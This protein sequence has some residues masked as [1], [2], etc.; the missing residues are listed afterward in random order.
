VRITV[1]PATCD[2]FGF[3]AELLPELMS[4]DEWGFPI[5]TES[6]I[7]AELLSAARQ[8]ARV[9]PRRAVLLAGQRPKAALQDG[10]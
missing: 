2:G 10:H 1:D 3:C 9:C 5:V 7:P 8:A 6:E 4:L